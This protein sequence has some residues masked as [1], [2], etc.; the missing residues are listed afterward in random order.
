MAGLPE[1]VLKHHLR[2]L[3]PIHWAIG[4]VA[5]SMRLGEV[6]RQQLRMVLQGI[7]LPAPTIVIPEAQLP[8]NDPLRQVFPTGGWYMK[9][10]PGIDLVLLHQ[11]VG[12]FGADVR[13]YRQNDSDPWF[14]KSYGEWSPEGKG[15]EVQRLTT[16]SC[17]LFI[18][19]PSQWLFPDSKGLRRDDCLQMQREFEKKLPDGRTCPEP[20]L[21]TLALAAFEYHRQHPSQWPLRGPNYA[22]CANRFGRGGW[23]D[24]GGF[25]PRGFGVSGWGGLG[26]GNL[27]ALRWVVWYDEE[28]AEQAA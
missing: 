26:G 8:A 22:R 28:E 25:D 7:R 2:N 17:H 15:S 13:F 3:E 19:D 23:L 18:P 12:Q 6:D 20:S 5:R 9:C 27:G 16:H 11:S 1:E 21:E 24:G 4:E 10:P 14:L